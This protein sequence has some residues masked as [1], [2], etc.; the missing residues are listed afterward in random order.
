MKR[1]LLLF[2]FLIPLSLFAG[3]EKFR[4]MFGENTSTSMI[5]GW[6]KKLPDLLT[7]PIVYYG[8]EDFGTDHTKYPL[9]ATVTDFNL[10]KGMVNQFVRLVD[11]E[12]NTKYYFVVRDLDGNSRRYYFITLPDNPETPISIVSGGDSRATEEFVSGGP[13][14]NANL[15]VSKLRPHML[16]YSGDYTDFD[17]PLEWQRFLDD[18]QLTTTEDGRM[19]PVVHT[20]GN[21][22]YIPSSIIEMFLVPHPDAYYAQTFGG[23]LLRIYTLN[24]EIAQGGAQTNWLRTDLEQNGDKTIYRFAN[25][26]RSIRPHESGKSPQEVAYQNW[27]PLFF[28]Y[29]FQLLNEGDSH[30]IKAT[31]PVRP[32][33]EEGNDRGFIR[34]DVNGFVIVGEGCWGAPVRAANRTYSWTRDADSFNG[35]NLIFVSKEKIEVRTIKYDNAADVASV[36]DEDPF[37]LPANLDVWNPSNGDVITIFPKNVTTSA[38][39]KNAI[40][41]N[42]NVFPNP[43]VDQTQ[44]TYNLPVAERVIIQLYDFNGKRIKTIYDRKTSAGEHTLTVDLS[45]VNEGN[46]LISVIAGSHNKG[47]KLSKL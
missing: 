15:M 21:H 38:H 16:I 41:I 39:S 19:F 20:R 27:V 37:T 26:H 6:S 29:G 33:T 17:T 44:I 2:V 23:N 14:V 47:F 1:S 34:D 45:D 32:S 18:W 28:Q 42:L 31:W 7:D 22:E 13:R 12:P 46:Y 36:T 8:K 4:L 9:Q 25:Y 11:L 10:G 24:T 30:V 5:I 40:Q 43:A 35:Y 3:T